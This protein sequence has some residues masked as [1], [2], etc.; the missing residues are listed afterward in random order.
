M[1]SPAVAAFLMLSRATQQLISERLAA[2]V[3]R[4]GGEGRRRLTLVYPSPYPVAMSSLGFQTVYRLLNAQDDTVAERAFLPEDDSDRDLIVTYESLRPAADAAVIA[5]SVAYE[6]ELFGLLTCLAR[7]GLPL[8]AAERDGRQPLVLAGGPLTFVNPRPLLPFVDAVVMG[9][10]EPSLGPLCDAVFQSDSREAQRQRL[11][12]IPGLMVPALQGDRPPPLN[13]CDDTALPAKAAIWTSHSALP[14]MFLVEAARGCSRGCTFCLMRRSG[15]QGMRVVPKTRI[16][17]AIPENA[18]RVGL[19]GAAVSDHPELVSL[20][21]ALVDRGHGVGLSSLRADRVTEPLVEA[22]VAGGNRTLTIAADGASEALRSALDKHIHADHL[23]QA[24]TLAVAAEVTQLKIYVMV[25]T[26]D[27]TDRDLEEFAGLARELKRIL[28]PYGK[29]AVGAS[30]FVPKPNTPLAHAPFVGVAE[31][32]RRLKKLR[33]DLFGVATLGAAS[34]RWAA[35]EHLVATGTRDTGLALFDA[36]Q[37][38]GSFAAV[39][40]AVFGRG[41]GRIA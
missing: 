22:L 37:A 24:A 19:V 23:R 36:W 38:G 6:L 26:P 14:Q 9:E 13:R 40:R 21:E 16:L 15:R 20:V 2:E 39:K 7:M 27:E 32:E 5:F 41:L 1:R 30:V 18:P 12:A 10:A 31:A 3:G 25:G 35:I 11:A 28:G 34:G 29:L 17:E 4:V 8:L 33:Q